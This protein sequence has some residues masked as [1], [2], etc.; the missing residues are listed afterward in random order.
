MLAGCQV[1]VQGALKNDRWVGR[2]DVL[3]RLETPSD[4]GPWSYE[5]IDTK[6][7]RETKGGA[8][9]QLCLYADLV[10]S[11]QGSLPESCY[12]V[13]PWSNYERQ[14]YRMDDYSAF[15]RRARHSLEEFLEAPNHGE[16]YPEP[17]DFCDV[18][19]WRAHCET[20]R[21]A[22]DHLC[23]V[24]GISKLQ[25]N[26]LQRQAIR[27][28]ANLA[29]MPLQLP[30]KPERGS[31]H[32]YQRVREQARI[33]VEGREAGRVLYELLLPVVPGFG[34][35]SPRKGMCFLISKAIVSQARAG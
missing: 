20:R 21:R 28:V 26:E 15:Y 3:K 5:V 24:A 30:W 19:G 12:I 34:R 1:I 32:A 7:A 13:A 35:P 6:L 11:V 8:V 9:L 4:L 2:A 18:C 25:T 14:K 17:K 31:V 16:D 27:T 22:D 10:K 29:E 23:L 33:Q